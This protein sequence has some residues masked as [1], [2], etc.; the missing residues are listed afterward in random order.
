M[1]KNIKAYVEEEKIKI[2]K[3]VEDLGENIPSL[4]ILQTG[5]D[6]SS[7]CY[8][9]NKVKD[10]SE[11]GISADIFK[12][13]TTNEKDVLDKARTLVELYDKYCSR[14]KSENKIL[15]KLKKIIKRISGTL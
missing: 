15:S 12:M 2:R 6:E 1:L 4:L 8:A 5:D 11:L 9:R 7:N 13:N 10:C 14:L 3:R